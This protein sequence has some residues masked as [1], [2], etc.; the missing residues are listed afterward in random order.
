MANFEEI[1]VDKYTHESAL[2]KSNDFIT[3]QE[4][5]RNKISMWEKRHQRDI[6]L[7][8]K[9]RVKQNAESLTQEAIKNQESLKSVLTHTLRVNDK[10]EWEDLKQKDKFLPFIFKDQK[11][12]IEYYLSSVPKKKIFEILIKSLTRKREALEKIAYDDFMIADK[13]YQESLNAAKE[14]YENDKSKFISEQ[15]DYN[16]GIDLL[17]ENFE[18]GNPKAIEEYLNIVFSKSIYPE[19]ISLFYDPIYFEE[20]RTLI[21]NVDLPTPESLPREV[22]YKYVATKNDIS[23]K[24]IKDKDFK[25]L[26]NELI[27]QIC[28]RSIH[29]V[30]ES[31]YTDVLD[32]VVFNGFVNAVDKKTG[33]EISNCILS[34]QAEK[35]YFSTLKLDKVNPQECISGMKGIIASEFIN[36]AP[37]KPILNLNRNDHRIIE[38]DEIID[39]YDM[40]NNLAD[41]DWQKF[42][43]LV[44]D[45]FS[46]EFSG[47]GVDVKVTQASR[48]AGVDGIIFDPDPIK[49]G[50]FII[51]AKRYN[52]VVGVSAVRDLYGTVVNEGAVKGILVTTSTFGKD[53]IDFAKDKPLTLISGSELVHM[54]SKHGY[55]VVIKTKR[56]PQSNNLN[57]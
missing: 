55:D 6:Q 34:V 12:T 10:I 41:M 40:S 11:P 25:L 4:K 18:K 37:V 57:Q 20:R 22:E 42:E 51:Q 35:S 54:F 49:G 15:E 7:K 17:K 21:L 24:Y 47:E 29:E 53:S 32:F 31:V 8:A 38:S 56:K 39:S 33:Q 16:N 28:I 1:I 44:R 13:K 48:D 50:K 23:I 9:E 36:L 19:F 46:K 27:A 2:I 30:Y 52:N 5:K 43:I 26:Y 45:L 14:K 3:F